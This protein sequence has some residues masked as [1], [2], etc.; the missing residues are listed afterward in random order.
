MAAQH[1]LT[2][3]DLTNCDREPIHQLGRVQS[4]GALVAVSDDWLVQHASDNL[5]DILGVDAAS[6][7]GRPISEFI[8]ADAFTRIRRSLGEL[9]EP[10][11][12]LRFFKVVLKNR[13]QSFDVSVHQSGRHLILEFEPKT[14]GSQR[15]VIS[16]VYPY[17]SKLQRNGAL[18]TLARGAAQGLQAISGFDSVMVYQFQPD[19]SGQ[20]LAEARLDG[21]SKYDGMFFPASDIPVQARALYK[22]SLLRLIADVDDPGSAINPP[23]KVDGAPLDLSLSVTRSVS[24]IHLE[25]LRN[26][27]VKASMSVSIMK[28]GEL[29]GLFACHHHSPRYIDYERRTAVEMFAHIFSYELS[30]YETS[31]RAREEKDINRLQ[32]R[33][34]AMMAD[35]QPFEDSL[36]S[37][38]RDI[39]DVIPHDGLLLYSDGV[40]HT[41]GT[42]PTLEET[43]ALARMLDGNIGTTVFSTNQL[44][45]IHPPAQDYVE[46]CAGI[47]AIPISKRPR[48][49]L[50]LC[51]RNISQTVSWAG[52]PTKPMSIGPNGVRLTPR[53]S[54]EVWKETVEW[55][56]S[57]WSDVNLYAANLLRTVLLEIFLKVTEAA[58]AERKRAQEQQQLLI[59][60]LNHRV[61]NILNLMRG[62]VSQTK[63]SAR[64][65]SEFT[66]N[67]D[68][69][70]HS[71]AR[72][73]DQL[74]SERWVPASL[75]T[76]IECEL[77]AYAEQSDA[78]MHIIGPDVLITPTAYTTLA[79]VL[80][81]LT[82]NSVKHGALG[83]DAGRVEITLSEDDSGALLIDWIERGGPAVIPPE[84]RGFGS[85]IVENSIPHE[86]K[87]DADISYKTSGFE[88]HFR[89]PASYLDCFVYADDDPVT[90][91]EE[92]KISDAPRLTGNALIVEDSLIIAMDLSAMME[93]M[94]FFEVKTASNVKKAMAELETGEFD[95]AVLDVNL[96]SEQSIPVAEALHKRGVPFVLTTGYGDAKDVVGGYPPCPIVQKPISEGTLLKAL[97]DAQNRLASKD[98]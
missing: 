37:V 17:F 48:D 24:P 28:D 26:M 11:S 67:L 74:T 60:E 19:H 80:H 34:M 23:F 54:F 68:G 89:I 79:L 86:L 33:L 73:H 50:V 90:P 44:E 41:T 3:T 1:T 69:R 76:L 88:G 49:Y 31:Q 97:M 51:R 21:Q 40:F 85:L 53:K 16:E 2:Q 20:V 83:T 87:G 36:F 82:T 15:D 35:G 13:A 32:T 91:Q 27:G 42:T 52:D 14:S 95:F 61:R 43:R 55:R 66:D 77:E 4:Y 71:L 46:R 56:C 30:Q 10:D 38:S 94:G 75:R 93:D 72:A 18:A 84:R 7:I 59:A 98:S 29:W 12:S 25:Y 81:E 78:K 9:S 22:R 8:V 62:L 63:G 47:L 45:T 70:I 64:T 96:G 57:P 6:A 5:K 65:L 92:P 39:Q 58:N